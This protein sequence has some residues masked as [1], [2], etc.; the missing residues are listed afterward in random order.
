[1]DITMVLSPA[2][3]LRAEGQTVMFVAVDGQA[4]GLLGVA[5][6][7]VPGA[8]EAVAALRAEGLHLL[9]LTGDGYPTAAALAAKLGID[10]VRA[11]VLPQDRAAAIGALQ[12]EGRLVALAAHG[13]DDAATLAQADL[14]I[15]LGTAAIAT[16][17]VTLVEGDLRGLVRARRM[18]RLTMSK[19]RQN[20]LFAFAYNAVAIP[21]AAG[22]LYPLFGF[23]LSPALAA[24]AMAASSLS[25]IASSLRL[26]PTT[27]RGENK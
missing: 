23:L 6:P 1:V 16:A 24:A 21:V 15:A 17:A 4:T 22:V 2:D 27:I 7:L 5:D 18:S 10:Q 8:A 20:L 26:R 12:A 25:V 19:I 9:M 14:G 13:I 3:G 11:E